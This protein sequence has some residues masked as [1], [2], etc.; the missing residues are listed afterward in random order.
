[1]KKNLFIAFEG[2]DGSGKT[3]QANLLAAKMQDEGISVYTTSE[4]TNNRIGAILKDI[5]KHKMETDHRTIAA[6][7]VADRLDHVLN[8]E[9]GIIKKL[10][11]GN[12]VICDRYYF[13]SYA[14]QGTHI[15]IDWV[16]EA[17]SLSA[18]ILRPDLNIFIDVDPELSMKR[19]NHS[20]P[21]TELYE[22]VENQKQVRQ[23]FFEAFEKLKDQENI[24]ITDGNRPLEIIAKEIWNVVSGLVVQKQVL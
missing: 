6:L 15:D 19:V 8:K 22:T 5:F 4:P 20:R 12:A 7:F 23:K 18:D 3:T 14:Y 10:E 24:F 9:N 21:S 17:N 2:L 11:E 13:S 1:M 16:I